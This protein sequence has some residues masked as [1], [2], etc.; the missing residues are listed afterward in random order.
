MGKTDEKGL[1]T[2]QVWQRALEFARLVCKDILPQFP[3]QERYALADQLRRSVQSVPA[4]IA[5]GY[6]RFYFQESVRFCYIARGSLEEAFSQL[7]LAHRMEYL[8]DAVYQN[9]NEEIQELKRMLNGYI[10]F[11]KASKRGLTEPGSG[12]AVRE[13][14]VAYTTD[15]DQ[16]DS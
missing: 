15:S 14:S 3:P 7:T 16:P 9:L 13:D 5:E 6:G 1:E 2:L 11:L 4:N 12:L 10:A 8:P